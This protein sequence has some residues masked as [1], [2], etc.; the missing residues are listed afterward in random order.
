MFEIVSNTFCRKQEFSRHNFIAHLH[1]SAEIIHDGLHAHQAFFGWI[2]RIKQISAHI[3][4]AYFMAKMQNGTIKLQLDIMRQLRAPR[5]L[6]HLST[7]LFNDRRK[8]TTQQVHAS[9][10]SQQFTEECRFQ[11]D[12]GHRIKM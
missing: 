6:I 8:V 1:C 9:L 2:L 11:Q 7:L 12:I 5:P 4:E 10:Q 3:I